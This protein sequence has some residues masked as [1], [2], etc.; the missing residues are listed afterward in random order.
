MKTSFLPIVLGCLLSAG[1]ACGQSPA[2]VARE[3]CALGGQADKLGV[4]I[5]ATMNSSPF[6]RPLLNNAAEFYRTAERIEKVAERQ[7][8]VRQMQGDAKLL[9]IILDR[10]DQMLTEAEVQGI[11]DPRF[12]GSVRSNTRVVRSQV[13]LMCQQV[14][15]LQGDLE[16]LCSMSNRPQIE[17]G[18]NQ[19]DSYQQQ[20]WQTNRPYSYNNDIGNSYGNSVAGWTSSGQAINPYNSYGNFN[21][22]QQLQNNNAHGLT[23]GNGRF[24]LQF[25]R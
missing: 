11:R 2:F 16:S 25:G 4:E 18:V 13:A 7:G 9:S 20:R 17:P 8:N 23:F 1:F 10:M 21:G 15:N 12:Y 24:T 22:G 19:Q 3:A 5:E 14:A 6:E